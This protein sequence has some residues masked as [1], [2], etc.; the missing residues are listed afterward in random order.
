MARCHRAFRRTLEESIDS[1]ACLH[2]YPS[3]TA[4][5]YG[6]HCCY[7]FICPFNVISVLKGSGMLGL[8]IAQHPE[9]E[10]PV[11]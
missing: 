6:V 2:L 11:Y 5:P 8:I 4:T 3:L 9:F 10:L 1:S 7:L